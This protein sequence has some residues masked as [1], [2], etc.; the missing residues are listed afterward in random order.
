VLTRQAGTPEASD[1]SGTY[2][3]ISVNGSALPFSHPEGV[4]IRSGVFTISRDGTCASR[5]TFSVP[6]GADATREVSASYTRVGSKLTMT[7][8]GA[9]TTTGTVEGN[10]FT[11]ENEGVTFVFRK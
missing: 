11:M 2:T 5:M 6:S 7:W 3:L 1:I 8:T 9:G 10:T 4:V